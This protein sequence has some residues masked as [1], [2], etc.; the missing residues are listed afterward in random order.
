MADKEA[1]VILLVC[2]L[3][4]VCAGQLFSMSGLKSSAL[5]YMTI[6]GILLFMGVVILLF[7]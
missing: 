4:G 6:G 2:G 1:G 7:S 5:K 3:M